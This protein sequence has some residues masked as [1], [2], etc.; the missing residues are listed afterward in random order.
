MRD[1]T[2]IEP[3]A[4]DEAFARRCDA[5][6]PLAGYRDRFHI[7]TRSGGDPAIYFAGNSLGLQPKSVRAIIDEE[8]ADWSALGVDAHFKGRRP[9]YSYHELLREPSARLVGAIPGEVV[10]M[11]SLTL[12]LHLMMATFY[13]PTAERYKILMEDPAFPSDTYA[14]KTQ[15]RHHGRDPADGLVIVQPRPGEHTVRAEDIERELAEHG[16]AIALVMLAG[17]NFFTGQ[18]MDMDRITAAARSRGCIAGWDLAHAAGNV[19]LRLHD[20]NVDF[21]VWCNYKYLNSGPGAVGGCFVH[22]RHGDDT[23]LGRL[24][25]WWGNDPDTRFRMH[26]EPEFTPRA[27]ADGWQISN[28]PILA[29]APVKTSYDLFDEVGMDALRVKSMR[30]TGYLQFMID[31]LSPE[32]FEVITPRGADARGCQLSMLVHDR[33]R[34]LFDAL[35]AEGV[36]CDFR[37]PNVIRVA[38]VP[39]Y[40]SFHDVWRFAQV[41]AVHDREHRP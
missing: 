38:P 15:L 37:E 1:P 23:S 36:V 27:G 25:G 2:T 8:L 11:N 39:L 12:N 33:P 9:W 10:V 5:D 32:R 30:L 35:L 24:G 21:A 34:A 13:R 7:P 4:P 16:D 40:N 20:W 31:R 41:L 17:V 18:V 14:V 26:L 22:Q 19:P 29:L 3:F 28:P 6:D